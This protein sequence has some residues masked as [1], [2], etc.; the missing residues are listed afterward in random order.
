MGYSEI[1]LRGMAEGLPSTCDEA[2]RIYNTAVVYMTYRCEHNNKKK[3]MLCWWTTSKFCWQPG[4]SCEP[5]LWVPVATTGFQWPPLGSNGHHLVS[6]AST[7]IEWFTAGFHW[8]SKHHCLPTVTVLI[9]RIGFQWSQLHGFQWSPWGFSG[10]A[11]LQW[12]PLVS[13]DHHWVWM[14]CWVLNW[15]AEYQRPPLGSNGCRWVL[16]WTGYCSPDDREWFPVAQPL[17]MSLGVLWKDGVRWR[18]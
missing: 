6:V 3:K 15:T 1:K 16:N 8:S 17:K 2:F 4:K 14:V 13:R 10:H 9:R 7:G 5:I 11:G 18:K 12:S